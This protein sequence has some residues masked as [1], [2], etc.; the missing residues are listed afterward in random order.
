MRTLLDHVPE[1]PGGDLPAVLGAIAEAGK[2]IAR[3]IV[4]AGLRGDLGLAGHL[5][6]QGE[7]VKKLDEIAHDI[8]ATALAS[9]RQVAIFLSEEMRDPTAPPG[10]R[11]GGFAVAFD[12]LDGS[13]NI[14]TNVSIGT[15]FSVHRRRAETPSPEDLLRPGREQVAAG[16]LVYGPRT[17]FT[18]TA[19]QGAH[20]FTFEPETGEFVLLHDRV[21]IPPKGRIYSTNEGNS[22]WWPPGTRQFVEWVKTEDEGSGRPYSTRYVGS[23]VADF[24]R[25][26]L[27]GGIFLYPEDTRD[28]KK[29]SGKLRLLYECAPIALVAEQ[30][31]GAASTGKGRVLDLEPRTLHERCPL[32]V[33]SREDVARYDEFRRNEKEST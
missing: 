19:G 31:E 3:E 1:I 32:V 26:L 22:P 16:Y 6:V 15:I 14:D 29:P 8:F 4:S 17:T 7:E 10:G 5:N 2:Q 30:A 13:S 25:T 28:P 20:T 27:H 33:G 9:C 18:Y 11:K 24:H 12:P 23:L 21:K